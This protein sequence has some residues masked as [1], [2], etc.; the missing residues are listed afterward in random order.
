MVTS[1]MYHCSYTEYQ[2]GLLHNYSNV[3]LIEYQING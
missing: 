1:T 2:L 3:I